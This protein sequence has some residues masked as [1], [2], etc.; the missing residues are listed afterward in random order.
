MLALL[1]NFIFQFDMQGTVKN[2]ATITLDGSYAVTKSAGKDDIFIAQWKVDNGDLMYVKQVGT[3][4]DDRLATGTG[5]ISDVD[6]NALVL[7]NTKGSF[8]REK[9]RLGEGITSDIIIFS[10]DR[11]TGNHKEVAESRVSDEVPVEN[12]LNTDPPKQE[13]EDNNL[14]NLVDPSP[15]RAPIH[16][17]PVSDKPG[18]MGKPKNTEKDAESDGA[19]ETR[20]GL[21]V[22]IAFLLNIMF[23]SC[24]LIFCLRFKQYKKRHETK[25]ATGEEKEDT[26]FV[27]TTGSLMGMNVTMRPDPTA[28]QL[29]LEDESV[30]T[31]RGL[32]PDDSV[33]E[34]AFLRL[35]PSGT[36]SSRDDCY[37]SSSSYSSESSEGQEISAFGGKSIKSIEAN[38]ILER[39][40][41][42]RRNRGRLRGGR[43][44]KFSKGIQS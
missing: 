22:V 29:Y 37:T 44:G 40:R 34:D 3:S 16:A 38:N 42:Q 36:N 1:T 24:V 21:L 5:V 8:M 20:T 39:S 32:H 33:Y 18:L 12:N 6:G 26:T 30:A 15:T 28:E 27:L 4:H 23:V 11:E 25:V 7:A 43:D 9:N 31:I 17:T 41:R 35:E 14:D 10:I 13:S 2:G 19:D